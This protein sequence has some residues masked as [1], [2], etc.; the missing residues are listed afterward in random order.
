MSHPEAEPPTPN[1]LHVNHETGT[2]LGLCHHNQRRHINSFPPEVLHGVFLPVTPYYHG[3]YIRLLRLRLVCKYWIE[4]IDSTPELWTSISDRLRPEL[5]AMII[6]KSRHHLLDV[7]YGEGVLGRD[8]EWVQKIRAFESLMEPE[9]SRWQALEYYR[10]DQKMD[11]WILP[12]PLH[13]LQRMQI[14]MSSPDDECPALDAPRLSHVVANTCTFN[15]ISLSGLH[16]LILHATNLSLNRLMVILRASPGL[17]ELSLQKAALTVEDEGFLNSF[18]NKIPLPQLRAL[19]VDRAYVQSTSFLLDWIEAPGLETFKVVFQCA[20][21]ATDHTDLSESVGH[22]IGAYPLPKEQKQ[23]QVS[24][25]V[26]DWE[27]RISIGE[28][29]IAIWWLYLNKEDRPQIKLSCISSAINRM[30]SR[31]CEEVKALN[32]ACWDSQ[33]ASEYLRIAHSRFPQIDHVSLRVGGGDVSEVGAVLRYLGSP[34]DLGLSEGW[35]LPKLTKLELDLRHSTETDLAERIMEIIEQ[36]KAVEQ[37]K[38]II[39]LR[40][41]TAAGTMD[42]STVELLRESV[43]IFDLIEIQETQIELVVDVA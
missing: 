17:R 5:Q 13:S 9:T 24:I 2:G 27:M 12:R 6:Q 22:H 25:E 26:L 33:E 30:D 32:L 36:R 23:A 43:M 15:R 18:T 29:K 11:D 20:G 19:H 38:D 34:S 31:V 7:V 41:T 21:D 8:P 4:V 35:L 16:V 10:I 37:T 1:N 28:D 39:E 40:V 3:H 14:C 42:L